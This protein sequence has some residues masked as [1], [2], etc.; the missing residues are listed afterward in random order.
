MTGTHQQLLLAHLLPLAE[1]LGVTRG[2]HV[3][4]VT[5]LLH[6]HVCVVTVHSPVVTCCQY[7]CILYAQILAYYVDEDREESHDKETLL[8]TVESLKAQ[9]EEQTRLCKEQVH[10]QSCI[11]NLQWNLDYLKLVYLNP[12]LSKLF[13]EATFIMNIIIIYKMADLL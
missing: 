9:L 8:L 13:T 7:F 4:V 10:T 1:D 6:V 5:L 12:R 11:Y 2:L 3:Q